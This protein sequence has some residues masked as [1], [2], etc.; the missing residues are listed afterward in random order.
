MKQE[1][2]RN[3]TI[4]QATENN[5][6]GVN[7]TLPREAITVFTGISG[8]GKSSLLFDVIHNEAQRRYLES[9]SVHARQLIGKMH[10]PAIGHA[11]GLSP[12]IAV[13]Q[14]SI[15]RNP[16]STAGTLSEIYDLLRLLFARLGTTSTS[17]KYS[18]AHFSFNTTEGACKNCHGLGVEDYIDP[19]L[20]I[21]DQT[22][23]LREGALAITTP[24]GYTIYSQVTIDVMNQ[25]CNAHGFNVDIPWYKLTAEQKDIILNGSDIITIPYGKHTLESR[26]RWSGITAKPREEGFYKGILPVM[27]GILKRDRNPNILRFARTIACTS[28]G[29][30]RLSQEALA[31]TFKG[32]NISFFNNMTFETLHQYFSQIQWTD[33]ERNAGEQIAVA[34]TQRTST[35]IKLGLEYLTCARSAPSLS[36]GEAQRIRLATQSTNGLQG[37]TY[38]LD[39]PSIGLHPADNKKML[40][41]LSTIKSR[42][43]TLLI[44]EHDEETMRQADYIVDIGPGAGKA[45]GNIL[46]SGTPQA[47]IQE[48]LPKS[49]THQWLTGVKKIS[50]NSTPDTK[51]GWLTL[52]KVSLHN[53]Q[54]INVQF[55]LKAINVITG[56]SGAG[57]STLAEHCLSAILNN[58]HTLIRG[59]HYANITG[60]ETIKK[61]ILINQSPIGRTPRSNPATYTKLADALRDLYASQPL[62]ASRGWNKSRFSFNTTGGR[63]EACMGAGVQQIGMHLLGDVE[64][65]CEKCNGR[66]FN[67][68]TLEITY[69]EKNIYDVMEM[70]VSDALVFFNEE[71]K[72]LRY[73]IILNQLGLGYITLGQ[74]STTLSGGE[75]QRIKLAA[76]LSKKSHAHTLYIFDEPTTGLHFED[77]HNLLSA[78]KNLVRQGHTLVITEH[79]PHIIASADNII[80]LG[81]G[82]GAKGG[83]VV[84]SG[85]PQN[86]LQRK[87]T[88]TARA[89]YDTL[90]PQVLK[91]TKPHPSTAQDA[92]TLHD[93][94]TNNL[95]HINV[96]IPHQQITVLTGPSGSGK[97]SLAFDTLFHLSRNQYMESFSSYVRAQ[98]GKKG[99][100]SIGS[101]SGL[102]APVAI[103]QHT[104]RGN[105]RSTVGTIT[106][107]YDYYRLLFSRAAHNGTTS[108]PGKLTASHFSFNQQQG[109]CMYCNGSGNHRSCDAKK[110]IT[111]PQMNI[112]SGAM[113][114]TKT[115]KF[116]GDP[117]GQH[118]AILREVCLQHNIDF[119]LPW[120]QYNTSQQSIILNGTANKLYEVT[121]RF[122]RKNRSGS[123]Q[124]TSTWPGLLYY[125]NEEYA[126]K[127]ADKRGAAMMDVMHD[128]RCEHC[129]GT[130][131]R[132]E[133]LQYQ[134][135]GKNIHELTMLSVHDTILFFTAIKNNPLITAQQLQI[136]Q[137]LITTILNR[138]HMI[139]NIGLGYLTLARSSLSLSGGEAQRLRL[140]TQLAGHMTGITYI[141]D[142]PSAGLHPR[143]INQLI[144]LLKKLC[145]Q[146][147]SVVVTEHDE[148]IIREAGHIIDM[149]PGA[150]KQGGN[151]TATGNL[152]QIINNPASLTGKYLKN[153]ISCKKTSR[154]ITSFLTIE[155]ASAHNLKQLDIT[156]PLNA[157]TVI[158]GVS[159]SGKSSLLEEVLVKSIQQSGPVNCNNIKGYHSINN[160]IY[161]SQQSIG[162]S[163]LSCPATYTGIFD[164][165]RKLF[166]SLPKAKEHHLNA[167]HFSY[168]SNGRCEHCNGMGAT[169]IPLDFLSDVW[170]TCSQCHGSRYT[171]ASLAV[172]WQGKNIGELLQLTIG[173][174]VDFFKPEQELAQDLQLLKDTGLHY[175]KL[176]QAANTLSGGESQRLKLA[177]ELIKNH[178]KR[179]LYCFDE[180]T[181]GLHFSDTEILIKLFDRLIDNG[182]TLVVVEHHRGIISHADHVIDL[183]PEGGDA[184][185]ELI[186]SGTPKALKGCLKSHTA[187]YL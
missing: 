142:E 76:E 98:A 70:T 14:K 4:T 75:A 122:K 64:I 29:G 90:N 92:I 37:I 153:G 3:I 77:V 108:L 72:L 120:N 2:I 113:N 36:G 166:A 179:I 158:T 165:I 81:P 110:L 47:F 149:G 79:H 103:S 178:G 105:S 18:R 187:Q 181:A 49:L 138:L 123:H 164:K 43:N 99:Q 88:T 118:M 137:D 112:H 180:P 44:V 96:T 32:E 171:E 173:E 163:P 31:V 40:D 139:Q 61:V 67:E 117:N 24:S 26:M 68:E 85:T 39:E 167:S 107:I 160:V 145:Q 8:S 144:Q 156:I 157:L 65:I 84:F 111:N 141:L 27:E 175:I 87:S 10:R 182:H 1:P 126:R 5:L 58:D 185:G 56:V 11:H 51:A 174:A 94:T 30:S 66:R 53:L 161:A 109:A 33:K 95:N 25:V 91:P 45:G 12:V 186:F 151:I 82:S 184:G 63:C 152:D 93:V 135:G 116:Y 136:T 22:K 78:M 55:A 19:T 89:L 100:Y 168:S 80:D 46:F 146:G 148:S 35:L 52:N 140:A 129:H 132:Q 177:T 130:R 127:H 119:N 115:G 121:W 69:K 23:T 170:Q 54:N 101:A 57:K 15:I 143:D 147:N 86:F 50:V 128:T 159:G 131:L 106:E 28:C 169:K 20:I 6:K 162:N 125:V 155:G 38:I 183:G 41:V 59:E 9:F 97:S 133:V 42:G 17:K 172:T 74:S 176:G 134:F 34:I 104:T 114:G 124:F 7:I 73:L 83:K 102:T 150:G 60:H 13:N 48:D 21:A 62:S 71:P 154:Q 16:R